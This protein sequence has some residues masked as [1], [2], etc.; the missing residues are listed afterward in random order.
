MDQYRAHADGIRRARNAQD[1]ITQHVG[2]EPL[3]VPRTMIANRP[4]KMTGTGSGMLRRI[5]PLAL[6]CISDPAARL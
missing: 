3:A 6:A 4:S 2:A 5:L 1:R